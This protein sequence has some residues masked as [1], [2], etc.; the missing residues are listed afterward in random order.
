MDAFAD[1]KLFG[2]TLV[3]DQLAVGPSPKYFKAWAAVTIVCFW[4]IAICVVLLTL[5]DLK[6][7]DIVKKLGLPRF[8]VNIVS[9]ILQEVFGF[10]FS[11]VL[12]DWYARMH[13]PV[14]IGDILGN[15]SG[16]AVCLSFAVIAMRY[17]LRVYSLIYAK[18]RTDRMCLLA[19]KMLRVNSFSFFVPILIAMFIQPKW[20]PYCV[21][22]GIAPVVVN[23]FLIAKVVGR[24]H[25]EGR[26]EFY[27]DQIQGTDEFLNGYRIWWINMLVYG[28]AILAFA[29]FIVVG[30]LKDEGAYAT[31]IILL[32]YFQIQ[33]VIIDEIGYEVRGAVKRLMFLDRRLWILKGGGAIS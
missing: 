24:A 33:R 1:V 12:V 17:Y 30:W 16:R 31:I 21:V 27:C 7:S 23:N 4:F 5:L 20:W 28:G 11:G 10:P 3:G 9:G 2:R 15:L 22:A 8:I 29:P 32:N 25:I 18:T 6:E 19:E 13:L 14:R 26:E